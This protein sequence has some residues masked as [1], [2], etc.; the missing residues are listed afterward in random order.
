METIK[1]EAFV[2]NDLNWMKNIPQAEEPFT[3]IHPMV[4]P[5]VVMLPMEQHLGTPAKPIVEVDDYVLKGQIIAK[6]SGL[7]SAN[8]HAPTS[9][10]VVAIAQRSINFDEAKRGKCIVIETDGKD[11]WVDREPC[12]DFQQISS[13]ELLTKIRN[14]GVVDIDG[15][16][17]PAHIALNPKK[18]V[19]TVIVNACHWN[20]AINAD[21]VALIK[22]AREV[23]IGLKIVRQLLDQ[24]KRTVIAIEQGKEDIVNA[25]FIA[26]EHEKLI[27]CEVEMYEEGIAGPDRQQLIEVITQRKMSTDGVAL[28]IGAVC[29]NATTVY[30]IYRAVCLGEASIAQLITVNGNGFNRRQTLSVP[31]GTPMSFVLKQQGFDEEGSYTVRVNS[32][33][34]GSILNH[35]EAPVNKLVQSVWAHKTFDDIDGNEHQALNYLDD[36]HFVD[37]NPSRNDKL[38]D[39]IVRNADIDPYNQHDMEFDDDLLASAKRPVTGELD[40]LAFGQGA[41]QQAIDDNADSEAHLF[42]EDGEQDYSVSIEDDLKAEP[43][44]QSNQVQH[45]AMPDPDKFAVTEDER[46]LVADN[47]VDTTNIMLRPRLAIRENDLSDEKKSSQAVD[48]GPKDNLNASQMDAQNPADLTIRS[49]NILR[50]QSKLKDTEEQLEH[51]DPS[52]DESAEAMLLSI[53]VLIEKIQSAK[54][55]REK[56][57][58]TEVD[59]EAN[60]RTLLTYMGSLQERLN[61]AQGVLSKTDRANASTQS[62]IKQALIQLESRLDNALSEIQTDIESDS[63]LESESERKE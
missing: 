16:G 28:T 11:E 46:E 49:Q 18:T 35:Q 7:V 50:L 4:V 62:A 53:N 39:D 61:L 37:A 27:N 44:E 3:K 26:I 36:L 55:L 13:T 14:A 31:L 42:D 56:E 43:V 21:D 54:K 23:V 12:P 48:K 6:A 57:K 8:I 9:G 19:N 58:Q 41:E 29:L 22:Y 51:I 24:P 38:T 32:L 20:N 10:T 15:E 47:D 40:S 30:S 1:R 17:L 33:Q 5:P 34:T 25:I 63:K 59:P 60:N 2:A 52:D 45:V